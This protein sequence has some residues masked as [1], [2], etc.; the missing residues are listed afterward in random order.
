MTVRS[1]LAALPASARAGW[2][3]R[4]AEIRRGCRRTRTKATTTTRKAAAASIDSSCTPRTRA[5]TSSAAAAPHSDH[6]RLV[7]DG[8]IPTLL[9]ATRAGAR[10]PAGP[11][12]DAR[13]GHLAQ[14]RP[15]DVGRGGAAQLRFGGQDQTVFEH[16]PGQEL[17]VVGN[18]IVAP[19]RGG[20]GAGRPL[21]RHRPPGADAEDEVAL[22]TGR[23]GDV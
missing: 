16:A 8:R 7:R 18:H 2:S 17:E 12:P 22:V 1:A 15:Q 4:P 10:L 9:A 21:E 14:H 13:H 11:G 23:L 6:P 3:T 19:R 5:P 20:V